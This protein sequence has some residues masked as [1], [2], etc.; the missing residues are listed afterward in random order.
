LWFEAAPLHT[1]AQLFAEKFIDPFD[2]QNL[3]PTSL[4]FLDFMCQHPYALAGG[5][6]VGPDRDDYGITLDSIRIP[7]QHVTADV[8]ADFDSFCQDADEV[9]TDSDLYCW[10]D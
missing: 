10:W 4:S 9:S 5:F 3:S 1:I 6:T 8:Q 7:A 2:R